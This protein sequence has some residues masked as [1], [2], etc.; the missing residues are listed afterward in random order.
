M[1]TVLLFNKFKIL[2]V[3]QI[4]FLSTLFFTQLKRAFYDV[5][6]IENSQNIVWGNLFSISNVDLLNCLT[7]TVIIFFWF[8]FKWREITIH[9][10]LGEQRLA[11]ILFISICVIKQ[12]CWHQKLFF[13][14]KALSPGS[15][16]NR[17]KTLSIKIACRGVFF[18][19]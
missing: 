14:L 18:E 13:Y 6:V 16:R 5:C 2:L 8:Y 11:I 3:L 9:L 19:A 17:T 1:S 4:W 7:K 15:Q 12:R 10:N